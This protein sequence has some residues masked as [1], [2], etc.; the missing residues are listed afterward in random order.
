MLDIQSIFVKLEDRK[1]ALVSRMLQYM[2]IHAVLG[3]PYDEIVIRRTEEG[4]PY[5]ANKLENHD[6]PNFNFNSSHH[7]DYVAIASEPLCL[8]GL[9]IMCHG[10]E[11]RQPALEFLKNFSSCFTISEW[12][13][14]LRAGPN[15]EDILNQF[16]RLWCLKEAYIKAVG[17]G[18]GYKLERME[19]YYPENQIW[20]DLAYLRID[21]MEQKDWQ[22]S[23]HQFGNCHWVCVARGPPNQAVS[24]YGKTLWQVEFDNKSYNHGFEL[25]NIPFALYEIEHLIPEHKKKE[26]HQNMF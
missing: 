6:F 14:I 12:T 3:I 25:P 26:Y 22:F 13:T 23:L 21:G 7:G 11:E 1:R 8:V 16:Y 10:I 17:V 9:D 20:S 2:L 19:F 24:S 5:L 4:K 18:L 15:D